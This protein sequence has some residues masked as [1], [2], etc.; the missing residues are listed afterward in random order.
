M[1]A[2]CL[3]EVK[4]KLRDLSGRCIYKGR[5]A[6]TRRRS[7]RSSWLP[8]ETMRQIAAE[9]NLAETAFFVK[10]A[11]SLRDIG[12]LRH[13]RDQPV[14][15]RDAG[16]RL[17]DLQLSRARRSRS[18]SSTRTGAAIWALTKQGDLLVLDFPAY[19]S[20]RS[21]RPPHLIDARKPP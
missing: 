5:S 3:L 8:D 20:R 10:N 9:N 2:L 4:M 19:P 16:K 15:P 7:C 18:S 17:C 6:E 21:R 12:G 13:G 1:L 14:R 11:M